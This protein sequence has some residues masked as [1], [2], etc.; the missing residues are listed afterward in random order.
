MLNLGILITLARSE[1]G[2][3]LLTISKEMEPSLKR[4]LY[5][6]GLKDGVKIISKDRTNSRQP[7][8]QNI[9]GCSEKSIQL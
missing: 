7:R 1:L 2:R 6:N 8:D 3:H 5:P 9:L 4:S